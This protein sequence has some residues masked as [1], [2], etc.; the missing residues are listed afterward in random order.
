M[1]KKIMAF[2]KK[3]FGD[4]RLDKAK[5]QHEVYRAMNHDFAAT[6][7]KTTEELRH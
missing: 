1:M 6:I 3:V 4:T 2:L 5:S 7:R